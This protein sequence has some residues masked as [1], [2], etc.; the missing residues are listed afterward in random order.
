MMLSAIAAMS[1][2]R[3]IG[4]K[5]QIPWDLP[6]DMKFF[7]NKTLGKIVVVGR[8]TLESMG[9]PL[10]SRRHIVLTKNPSLVASYASIKIASSPREAVQLAEQLLV[11]HRGVEPEVMVIGGALVYEQMMPYL[12][13]I[14]LTVIHKNIEGD[15][16]FPKVDEKEFRLIAKEEKDGFDFRIYERP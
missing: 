6:E 3:V 15:S 13:R 7:R 14:Y 5:N 9:G 2:N 16:Y 10:P 12:K 8:N 1:E 4:S 11:E